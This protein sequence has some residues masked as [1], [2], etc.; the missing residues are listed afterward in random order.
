M[1]TSQVLQHFTSIY[2]K[3]Y[4]KLPH[5]D[6]T[7]DAE[8]PNDYE[9][10]Y[11][12]L[13][14]L[15]ECGVPVSEP[16]IEKAINIYGVFKV[17]LVLRDMIDQNRITFE[18]DEKTQH[19]KYSNKDSGTPSLS[20]EEI[21]KHHEHLHKEFDDLANKFLALIEEAQKQDL[22]TDLNSELSTL[23]TNL[24]APTPSTDLPAPSTDLTAPSTD[25]P[26]P[27]TDLPA[28]S[29]D[30]VS[31]QPIADVETVVPS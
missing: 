28:P 2:N 13:I 27:S 24:P 3:E 21:N 29:S 25:L 20:T 26:A 16:I 6:N 11:V 12:A 15:G 7:D 1:K 30:Q 23:S 14:F 8:N 5:T 9:I 31:E 17:S 22:P 19:Y 4:E 10:E 18:F